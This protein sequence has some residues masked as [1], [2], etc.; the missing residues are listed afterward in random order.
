[1]F[2]NNYCHYNKRS[3]TASSQM[4]TTVSD[5]DNYSDDDNMYNGLDNDDI[6]VTTA[7]V[8]T[9]CSIKMLIVLKLH[10]QL[11]GE[12]IPTSIKNTPEYK[13]YK[14][15]TIINKSRIIGRFMYNT[16]FK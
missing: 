13:S 5:N 6:I 3:T 12:A 9:K 15:S 14:I 2:A 11:T 1:M 4:T 7:I 16:V 10:R 8:R